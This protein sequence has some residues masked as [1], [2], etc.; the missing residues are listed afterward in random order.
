ML[1]PLFWSIEIVSQTREAGKLDL[2]DLSK[3]WQ[4]ILFSFGPS[5]IRHTLSYCWERTLLTNNPKTLPPWGLGVF[6][7]RFV[8]HREIYQIN[9][10]FL[11]IILVL[12]AYSFRALF[13]RTQVAEEDSLTLETSKP[14]DGKSVWQKDDFTD[15]RKHILDLFLQ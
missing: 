11:Y 15:S 1:T 5:T 4:P 9:Y 10:S 3:G 6:Y 8:K 12:I 2:L 7:S 14:T 13:D